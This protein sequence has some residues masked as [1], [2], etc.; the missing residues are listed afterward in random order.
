MI[1][2]FKFIISETE[3]REKNIEK[4]WFSDPSISIVDYG[5]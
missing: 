2:T 1:L 5:I 4:L 3:L